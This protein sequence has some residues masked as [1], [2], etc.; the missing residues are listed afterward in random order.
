MLARLA[1]ATAA[2]LAPRPDEGRSLLDRAAEA[3]RMLVGA[4]QGACV[5]T[6]RPAGSPA[7][8]SGEWPTDAPLPLAGDPA[9]AA[10]ACAAG[11]PIRLTEAGLDTLPA[12]PAAAPD[13]PRDEVLAA[14]LLAADGRCRG[15]LV[16]SAKID[17]AAFD[18][19]DEAALEQLARV[20]GLALENARLAAAAGA[21]EGRFRA[22]VEHAPVVVYEWPAA[23]RAPRYV[24]PRLGELLGVAPAD[25]VARFAGWRGLLHP[26]DLPAVEAEDRRSDDAGDPFRADYRLRRGDG[27]WVWVRD[28]ATPLRD[29]DGNITAWQ[30][31]LMDISEERQAMAAL[32]ASE[33][34]LRLAQAAARV[35]SWDRDAVA[36]LVVRSPGWPA[37]FG[38]PDVPPDADRAVFL[39]R[40]HPADRAR[41][42]DAQRRRRDGGPYEIEYRVI[43]PDGEERWL[44]DRGESIPGP[45]GRPARHLGITQDVTEQRRAET[46]WRAARDAAEAAER[47]T[48][49]TLDALSDGFISLD[50]DGR[51]RRLNPAAARILQQDAVDLIGR[52]L[53][54]ALPGSADTAFFRAFRTAIDE[55]TPATAVEI[56]PPLGSWFET[57]VFPAPGGASVFVRDVGEARRAAAALQE[58][59]D[60]LAAIVAVQEEIAA[61]GRDPAAVMR[62]V[63]ERARELAAADGAGLA[64]V[65]G[66]QVVYRAAAGFAAEVVG[67]PYPIAGSLSGECLR[68]NEVV[69]ADDARDDA[70]A[71]REMA[72]ALGIRS[73]LLAP[74]RH[75]GRA[76]GVL[77]LL[78]PRPAAFGD[79]DAD[80][81]RL[82]AGFVGSSLAHA[83]AFAAV[84]EASRLKSSFLSTMSH[85]LRTPLNAII[86]YA[87]LLLDGMAGPLTADQVG[88]VRQI[89][90]GADR[91]LG[92]VD[93]VLD[94]S[95]IEA[96]ALDLAPERVDLASVLRAV[97]ADVAPQALAKKL[98][99]AFDVETGLAVRADPVR[100]RQVLLNLV[101]NAVKFTAA[102]SITVRARA[103]ADGVEIA[104]ADTGIGIAPGAL[105]HVFDE[106]R[107]ADGSTTRRYGGSGLGL[108][109]SKRLVELHGGRITVESEPGVGSTF[110]VRLP[111]AE[112]ERRETRDETT[113]GEG[114]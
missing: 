110:L 28:V 75:E 67:A 6:D 78:S 39:E 23:D 26:D 104:V 15:V 71:R 63:V 1:D 100:L 10:L 87:H 105:A 35:A 96:G 21:S 41:L 47:L 114:W 3:A 20:I 70:R 79:R 68:R 81:L 14:P 108:A 107:Q 54:Q 48:R 85:E 19:A 97:R 98:T 91:L 55:G 7:N 42:I 56:V 57:R 113:S 109:I 89:T 103:T 38:L 4:G 80:L 72:R 112:D 61:A 77:A 32:G 31:V 11:R 106:F 12:A 101:G 34:R 44:R 43:H 84:Q 16:V 94:L 62:L 17:G 83:A 58:Q 64:L 86:G 13:S 60:R 29:D 49:D 90:E 37:L 65:E 30:G 59:A 50:R 22:L 46:A 95:R 82:M 2:V 45:D 73:V 74:L 111:G 36:D 27:S 52:N 88:D 76:I 40:V 66:D 53:W 24:S 25:A 8:G 18:A 92:L 69:R 93:D 102:G 99:L 9:V 5:E 51:I 33:E